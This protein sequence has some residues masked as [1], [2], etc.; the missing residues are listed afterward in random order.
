M[1]IY[2]NKTLHPLLKKPS[3]KGK[4]ASFSLPMI[5]PPVINKSA[6]F[7]ENIGHIW[8]QAEEKLKEAKEIIIFGYSFPTSDLESVYLFKRALKG[9]NDIQLSIIDPDPSVIQKFVNITDMNEINWFKSPS[10]F[11]K[12][13]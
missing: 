1:D 13:I 8:K 10:E 6:I 12:H 3:S 4:R 9:R 5:V 2:S 11:F 7:H